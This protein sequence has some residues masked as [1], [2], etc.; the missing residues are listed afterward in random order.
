ME[1]LTVNMLLYGHLPRHYRPSGLIWSLECVWGCTPLQHLLNVCSPTLRSHWTDTEPSSSLYQCSAHCPTRYGLEWQAKGWNRCRGW[2]SFFL[3]ISHWSTSWFKFK[4]D[5]K[6]HE[7]MKMLP[8]RW[9]HVV[10]FF[11]FFFTLTRRYVCIP[12]NLPPPFS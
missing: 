1:V 12:T 6:F 8:N 7:S 5:I 4:R 9:I 3:L 2:I 10:F 11:T